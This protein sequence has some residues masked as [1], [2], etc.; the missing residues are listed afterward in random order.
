[1]IPEPPPTTV[2]PAAG[3]V[4]VVGDGR[5]GRA[6]VGALTDAGAEVRGPARHGEDGRGAAIV[7]LAVPDAAIPAAAARVGAGPLVGHLS[8]SLGLDALAPHAGFSLHPLMTVT[9]AGA[10]F[11]G[12]CAAIDAANDE[13]RLSA[14]RIAEMLGMSPFRVRAEDRAAYHAAASV[15]SNFLVTLEGFA[16][17]LAATAGVPRAA[18]VPLVRAS[19]ENWAALGAETALT[20]PVARGDLATIA[21][22]RAAVAERLPARLAVFDALVEATSDIAARRESGS[23]G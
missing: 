16:E 8:G 6:L 13:A 15:A 5:M 14:E 7:L 11:G 17:E 19:V 20:G 18:L 9:A 1:M 12:V 3:P 4:V 21:R 2:E 22:Q 23:P 10:H